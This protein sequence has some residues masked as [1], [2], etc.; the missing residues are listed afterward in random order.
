MNELP[1]PPPVELP[2]HG[3][4]GS[5]IFLLAFFI[6]TPV[7]LAITTFTLMTVSEKNTIRQQEQVLAAQDAVRHVPKYANIFSS[8]GNTVPSISAKAEVGDA[9][10]E[11]IRQYLQYYNSPLLPYAEVLVS[12]ADKN[13]LDFRLTTAIAQQESNL[14]KKIPPGSYNCWGWGI[15][16]AGTLGFRSYEEGIKIV[17]KGLKENYIDKGYT[18]PEVIMTKYTPSSNG[19]WANGV[20]QFMFE[21]Q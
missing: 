16:S 21:M 1:P 18:T 3:F 15:H 17:S 4:L 11:I 10:V 14:C 19:S 8:S 2:K 6:L 5:G 13:Q 20:N 9:R 7:A 12:E